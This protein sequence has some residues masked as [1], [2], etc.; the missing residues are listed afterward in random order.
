[1]HQSSTE[2]LRCLQCDSN[3][4]LEI[5]KSEK[6]VHEG[7]LVC[8]NCDMIFPIISKIPILWDDFSDFLSNRKILSGRLYRLSK[9]VKMKNFIKSSLLKTFFS[10]EDRTNL[11]NRWS[12]IYQNSKNS[13]F[14]SVIKKNLSSV[15][16]SKVVLEYGCSI[17]IMTSYL[18]N[19]HDTVFGI[20]RSFSALEYAKRNYKQNL[21]FFLSDFLSPIFG[22]LNFDLVLALNV[23]ELVEPSNFL[24]QV[25]VQ[26]DSGYFVISD[27]YDF[28]RGKNSVKQAFDE[29]TLRNRMRKLGFAI[30]SSTKK[31]SYIKWNLKLNPR[32][33]LR[34]DVDL[35][36]GKKN[37]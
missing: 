35:V 32:S 25:S 27:P 11:D 12:N 29:S 1:M 6:E 18:S 33:Q 5:L 23:L 21:D 17:G 8:S 16:K 20:D 4:E 22:K 26:I 2:F 31:P 7:F 19:H 14:Y 36:I 34:Y 9:T 30:L 37:K 28:D 13:K 24:K 10:D 15:N 3:L